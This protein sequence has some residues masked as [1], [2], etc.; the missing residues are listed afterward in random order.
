MITGGNLWRANEIVICH[1]TRQTATRYRCWDKSPDE[2]S[3]SYA[4]AVGLGQ[5]FYD[6]SWQFNDIASAIFNE[7][8]QS[9]MPGSG[10]R[11]QRTWSENFPEK[12]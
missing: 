8:I 2:Y 4:G 11:E 5:R 1:H 10:E 6:M 9:L 12:D 7:F 3:C